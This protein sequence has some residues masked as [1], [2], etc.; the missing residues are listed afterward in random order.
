MNISLIVPVKNE[1]KS[2]EALLRSI[3]GQVKLPGEVIMIDAGSSDKTRQI[4]E[5]YGDAKIGLKLRSIGDAYPGTA[6]NAG[7]K[8][9][10]YGLIAFTDGGIELD[11]NWLK[12]LSETIETEGSC[13]VVYGSYI[14]KTDTF[15]KQCLALAV[16]PPAEKRT[17]FIASSLLKK[18]VWQG[19]D[20]FPD[21]RAA[22]DRIFMEEIAKKG[23][24]TTRNPK[25]VAVWNIPPDM[26]KAFNRFYEYSYH[27]LKAGRSGGWHLPVARMYLA[28]LIFLVLGIVVSPA[29]FILPAAGLIARVLKKLYINRKE[30]YFKHVLIPCYF[31]VTGVI[32]VAIDLSM[33]AGSLR[34]VL[35]R[36]RR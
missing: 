10:K 31:P 8:E 18:A 24:K 17:S 12:E 7:V 36:G 20:G 16:V 21:L 11:R 4:I 28:A 30:P 2:V 23:Y 27:D 9:A 13:D 35:E 34:Y 33:F 19:V 3:S 14:P 25:A 29:F 32:I 22:E 5:D 1:E 15:F 6:R 26:E